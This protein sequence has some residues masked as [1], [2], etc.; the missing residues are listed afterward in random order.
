[1]PYTK[2][3]KRRQRELQ[4]NYRRTAR[5]QPLAARRWATITTKTQKEHRRQR[6]RQQQRNDRAAAMAKY[7]HL[8]KRQ[9]WLRVLRKMQGEA[10][11]RSQRRAILIHPDG[12]V[13]PMKMLAH[14]V[15]KYGVIGSLLGG[16]PQL[17]ASL[18]AAGVALMGL[19]DTICD[20]EWEPA[21][22]DLLASL[23]LR[24]AVGKIYGRALCV[25]LAKFPLT[26]A[27]L[28]GDLPLTSFT[29]GSCAH[30]HYSRQRQATGE[31]YCPASEDS[32]ASESTS[33]SSVPLPSSPDL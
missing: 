2:G 27:V 23:K 28:L 14:T 3:W 30:V 9:R 5:E 25:R 20:D 18:P 12:S 24:K 22:Y 10:Q 1:M 15:N 11:Q 6:Q 13:S 7:V 29:T 32:E 16:P 4:A 31:F 8:N 17:L 21:A 19:Q 26:G 33:S